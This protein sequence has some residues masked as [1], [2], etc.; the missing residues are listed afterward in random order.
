MA[1]RAYEDPLSWWANYG[2]ATPLLQS[3]AFKLL[4]QPAS[5]S[6][7]ERNWSTFGS[8]QTVKRNRLTSKRLDD[9]VYIHNNLRLLFRKQK[10]YTDGPS[11]YWD[12]GGDNIDGETI[13]EVADLSLNEPEIEAISFDI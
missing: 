11:K 5:S 6:C 10:E 9:L 4:S 2:S 7:C 3:L 13:L 8:F 1:A 12:I